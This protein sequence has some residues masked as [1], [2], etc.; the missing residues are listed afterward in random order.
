MGDINDLIAG[1]EVELE[2]CQKRQAKTLKER[3][4]ILAKVQQDGR[5]NLT[6]EEQT[7][8]EELRQLTTT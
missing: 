4:F 2:A 5:S 6:D 1:I 8:N 7:R 3:E